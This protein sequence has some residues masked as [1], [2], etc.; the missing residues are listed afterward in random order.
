MI[1]TAFNTT[2][3]LAAL[4]VG[5]GFTASV[6]GTDVLVSRDGFNPFTVG[7]NS[8]ERSVR[9]NAAAIAQPGGY[10]IPVVSGRAGV[11]IGS[12]GLCIYNTTAAPG[13]GSYSDPPGYEHLCALRVMNAQGQFVPNATLL[14]KHDY[15]PP[16]QNLAKVAYQATLLRSQVGYSLTGWLLTEPSPL[17]NATAQFA[18]P[19]APDG[20]LLVNGPHFMSR[21]D[22]GGLGSNQG[23]PQQGYVVAGGNVR[24]PGTQTLALTVAGQTLNLR[25]IPQPLLPA[26]HYVYLGT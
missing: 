10:G 1:E 25:A 7:F 23:L 11:I 18:S 20:T 9:P 3:E 16:G 21:T 26:P 22:N 12:H 8:A 4:L 6:S 14:I 17:L 5:Q 15:T 24:V 2:D 13:S 19:V